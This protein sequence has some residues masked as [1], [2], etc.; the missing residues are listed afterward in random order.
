MLEAFYCRPS[1]AAVEEPPPTGNGACDA[2][3]FPLGRPSVGSTVKLPIEVWSDNEAVLKILVQRN[4][5]KMRHGHRT[6]RVN[7]AWV[8]DFLMQAHGLV[9]LYHVPTQFQLADIFTKLF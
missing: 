6:H 5:R 8:V 1:P 4:F 3:G 2:G 9:S 7:F